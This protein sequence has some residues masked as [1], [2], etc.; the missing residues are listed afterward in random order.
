MNKIN[1]AVLF[2]GASSEYEISLRSAASVISGLDKSKYDI[3]I[4]GISREGDWYY[5]YITDLTDRGIINGRPDG[6]FAPGASLTRAEFVKMLA[7]AFG[8]VGGD[9]LPFEDVTPSDW[10]YSY[11]LAAYAN[12]MVGGVSEIAFNPGGAITRE[13][14]CVIVYRYLSDLGILKDTRASFVDEAEFASY[15]ADAISSLASNGIVNGVGDNRFDP[16]ASIN[17]VSSAVLI[18]NCLNIK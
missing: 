17:R 10:H 13:D 4:V 15:A 1:L 8:F 9:T 3:S 11:I 6:S 2:G 7:S 14:A 16:K 12:G 18:L 5:P